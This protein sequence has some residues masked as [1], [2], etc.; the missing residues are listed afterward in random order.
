MNLSLP[1][2]SVLQMVLVPSVESL[3]PSEFPHDFSRLREEDMSHFLLASA[4]GQPPWLNPA[5]GRWG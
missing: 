5:R 1:G 2:F 3:S 4:G